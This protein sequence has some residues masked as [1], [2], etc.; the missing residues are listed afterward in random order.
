MK[1]GLYIKHG[2]LSK[3]NMVFSAYKENLEQA[4]K[5]FMNLKRLSEAEFNKLFI[6]V[7]MEDKCLIKS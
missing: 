4:K 7:K 1:F 2:G 6:V 3:D 5:H